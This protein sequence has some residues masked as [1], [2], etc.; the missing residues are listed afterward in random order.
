MPSGNAAGDELR[1]NGL[2][3]RARTDQP[4]RQEGL[5]RAAVRAGVA[6]AS[7]AKSDT[8]T[9]T[10]TQLAGV[11]QFSQRTSSAA[12]AV[13]AQQMTTTTLTREKKTDGETDSENDRQGFAQ[14]WKPAWLAAPSRHQAALAGPQDW[15]NWYLPTEVLTQAE[16]QTNRGAEESLS[17]HWAAAE[18]VH[19][20]LGQ[21]LRRGECAQT[22]DACGRTP[23]TLAAF[24]GQVESVETIL[25]HGVSVDATD[26]CRRTALHMAAAAGAVPV[27]ELL[28]RYSA[29]ARLGADRFVTAAMVAAGR[30][31]REVLAAILSKSAVDANT[32]WHCDDRRWHWR[33]IV[34]QT[35]QARMDALMWGCRAGVDGAD[36]V[37]FLLDHGAAKNRADYRGRS[38]LGWAA[39]GGHEFTV[40]HSGQQLS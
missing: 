39:I 29:D 15:R 16:G 40:R 14:T 11:K 10:G 37:K 17:L 25:E 34:N 6:R 33:D 19:H 2:P 8:V 27:V 13:Y 20:M 4:G 28:L 24:A 18:G 1:T 36:A 35:D 9:H 23:L 12:R 7:W 21:L 32:L 30:G 22:Y 31:Q 5:P 3:T 26:A 38:A